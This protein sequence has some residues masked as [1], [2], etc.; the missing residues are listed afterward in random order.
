MVEGENQ[1]L[2]CPQNSICMA[3]TCVHALPIK[4]MAYTCVHTLPI[5][6]G[7]GGVGR[8]NTSLS[9]VTKVI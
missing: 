7:V 5:K 6:K 9:S 8:R 3:Y 1:H 2:D 4:C